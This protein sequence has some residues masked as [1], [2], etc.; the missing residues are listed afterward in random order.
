MQ[1]INRILPPGMQS[2][3]TVMNRI[4]DEIQKLRYTHSRE[5]SEN[6]GWQETVNRVKSVI[7][8]KADPSLVSAD[9]QKFSL[10]SEKLPPN[11]FYTDIHSAHFECFLKKGD[12]DYLVVFFSGARSRAGGKLAPYPTFSSW[13]WY[14]DLNVSVLCIDDPMYKTYPEMV[15]GWYYGNDREDYRSYT[16]LLIRKI[17]FLL[18]VPDNHIVL[19][20]RSGGG[21]AAI[22]VSDYISGSSVC[23]INAQIALNAY[24]YYADQ[25]AKHPGIDI[26]TSKDFQK[27]NDFAGIIKRHPENTYLMITNVFSKSDA[28]RSIPYYRKHFNAPLKY[29]ISSDANFHSWLYSAWG[30]SDAHN[31]FDSVSLFKMILEILLAFSN[32][33]SDTEVN[34]LAQFANEYWFERYNHIIKRDRYE[35]D[36]QKL[37]KQIAELDSEN[38]LLE[39]QVRILKRKL[40]N[41]FLRRVK[42]FIK[43]RICKK[44]RI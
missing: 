40:R 27:R 41:R 14:K 33:A 3:N 7:E 11:R 2:S 15:I 32:G 17:A 35:K 12:L 24:S 10:E 38:S 25:F 4:V 36:I 28:E 29:G 37:E 9:P 8:T 42:L 34:I 13:S 26:Y 43:K 44:K 39:E 6:G 19:Y 21:T 22:A 1:K 31:S 18:G 16:A 23:S 30:V 5:I 20:G